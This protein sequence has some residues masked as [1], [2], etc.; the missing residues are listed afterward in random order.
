MPCDAIAV[1]KGQVL[2]DLACELDD[3]GTAAVAQTLLSLLRQR[4]AHLGQPE[5]TP[6]WIA[7]SGARA[8]ACGLGTP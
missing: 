6:L 8:S 5:L 7:H 4:F 2:L 1:A 3:L